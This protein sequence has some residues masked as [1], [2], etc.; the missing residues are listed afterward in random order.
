M[1]AER[2]GVT[3]S[4]I[5]KQVA[6]LERRLGVKLLY[7]TTRKVEITDIGQRFYDSCIKILDDVESAEDA[8][9][10]LQKSPTGSIT[11]RAPHSLAVL[12][13]PELISQFSKEYRDLQVTVIVDEY[14]A[15]SVA[16]IERGHDL[17]LHLGP[18][19]PSSLSMRELAEVEWCPYASPTYLER[20]GTPSAP[21]DLVRHNCLI[22]LETAPDQRW[23]FEGREGLV[24]VKVSGSLA[25][26]SSLMLR[27]AVA[28]GT[29]VAMLP[30]F[31]FSRNANAERFMRLLSGYRSPNRNLSVIFA[32]DRRLPRRVRIFL[33]F[34]ASWFRHPPWIWEPISAQGAEVGHGLPMALRREAAQAI[35]FAAPSTQRGHVGLNPRSRR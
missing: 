12:H 6:E 8:A 34:M 17:A 19:S 5:S 20:H 13:L 16:A 3:P 33:D 30:S 1:A 10:T 7:R 24:S 29:G 26:N 11:L 25:S 18:V 14:P 2:L 31:C 22:H 4:L 23:K 32:R 28:V 35:A 21:S 9:R 15:R 27:D